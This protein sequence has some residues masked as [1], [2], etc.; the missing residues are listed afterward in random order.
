VPATAASFPLSKHTGASDTAPA[1]SGQC[2]YLQFMWEVGL[3]PLLW[4]FPPFATLTSFPTLCCWAPRP[5]FRL[6]WTGP[7]C[8]FTVPGRILLP[9]PLALRAPHPLCYVSLLFLLLITQFLFFPR[10]GSVCPGGYADLAQG[11][12]WE[13]RGTAKLTLSTSSQAV[14]VPVTGSGGGPQWFLRST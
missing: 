12:L 9:P 8:L 10:W 11:C 3:L 5:C 13:Y 6:L 7:A 14:W 4:S 1:F 2:V